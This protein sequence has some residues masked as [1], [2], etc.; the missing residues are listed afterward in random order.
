MIEAYRKTMDQILLSDAADRRILDALLRAEDKEVVPMKQTTK[1][2]LS[3]AA[4]AALAAAAAVLLAAAGWTVVSRVRTRVDTWGDFAQV[5]FQRTDEDYIELGS[6]YPEELPEGYEN[7]FISDTQMGSQRL[8]FTNAAGQSFDLVVQKAGPGGEMVMRPV[9]QETVDIDGTEGTLYRCKGDS[10]GEY[11]VLAWAKE[12]RGLGFFMSSEDMTLDLTAIACSVR[13]RET[14]LTPTYAAK[15]D[16]ARAQLGDYRLRVLP[17]GYE[18]TDAAGVPVPEGSWYGYVRYWYT[19]KAQNATL[20]FTYEPFAL[21]PAE[22]IDVETQI[23]HAL[24]DADDVE[25]REIC[26]LPGGVSHKGGVTDIV[27]IDREQGLRFELCD[28]PSRLSDEELLNIANSV[29]KQ[30]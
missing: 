13:E 7:S 23:R 11:Q 10:G 15:L 30:A 29:E 9:S 12:E 8:V 5:D 14:A 19:D 18:W 21:D 16:E 1:K 2:R 28:N 6:W 20:Y 25:F 27:W 22:P 26:G 17:E 4:V 24:G 3:R